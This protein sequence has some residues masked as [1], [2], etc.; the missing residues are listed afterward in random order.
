MHF[1]PAPDE[2]PVLVSIEVNVPRL[3]AILAKRVGK[4]KRGVASIGRGSVRVALATPEAREVCAAASQ[5]TPKS[6]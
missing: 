6:P 5:A 3:L 4:S 1:M 2:T